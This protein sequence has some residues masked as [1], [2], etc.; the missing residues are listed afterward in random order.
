V[1][2][3][4]L[5]ADRIINVPVVKVHALSRLTCGLKN[6]YGLLGGQR[7]LLHQWIHASIA[8]LGSAFLPTLTVTDA[9]RV[10]VRGGPQGGRPT[11]V[12]PV[13]AVAAGTDPVAQDA[14]AAGLVGLDPRDVGHIVL[15]EGRGLGSIASGS[16][17]IE[18]IHAGA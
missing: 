17:R 11:D 3:P 10:M 1:L 15:A 2:A 4:A 14:W 9:T 16:G 18:E 5:D 13:G 12:V 6:W 7:E 8:D